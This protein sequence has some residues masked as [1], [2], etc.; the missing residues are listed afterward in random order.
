MIQPSFSSSP[1]GAAFDTTLIERSAWFDGTNDQLLQASVFGVNEESARFILSFW[2]RRH[3]FA[4]GA[5]S[6]IIATNEGGNREIIRFD[7]DD[8][9]RLQLNNQGSITSRVFRDTAWYHILVSVEVG[10]GTG[11]NLYVNGEL[12]TLGTAPTLSGNPSWFNSINKIQMAV[13]TTP[14]RGKLQLAQVCGLPQVS[15][16][17]SDYTVANFLDTF[18]FG[19]NGSQ[20]VPKSDAAIVAIADAVGGNA[21]CLTTAIGDGTDASANGNNFT[22]TSMSDAANGSADTPSNIW[23]VW[24]RLQTS[25]SVTLLNGNLNGSI[26]SGFQLYSAAGTVVVASGKWYYEAVATYIFNSFPLFGVVDV[27]QITAGTNI[28]FYTSTGSGNTQGTITHGTNSTVY[29]S[30]NTYTSDGVSYNGSTDVIMVAFDADAGKVWF[31]KN[32][33]WFQSTPP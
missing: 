1:G 16:Q 24:N 28:S 29:L 33:V 9:L 3:H 18:N 4:V 26:S 27:S 25:S 19:A 12:E 22:P 8:K 17:N 6:P 20:Y 14:V 11:V 5:T 21:F 7:S 31:G 15:I 30:D 2:V 10:T 23:C 13:D 32:G